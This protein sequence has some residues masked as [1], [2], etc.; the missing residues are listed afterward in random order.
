MNKEAV[1]EQEEKNINSN[2]SVI[3][4]LGKG[5]LCTVLYTF[6]MFQKRNVANVGYQDLYNGRE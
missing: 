3:T 2:V 4:K 1:Q 6:M 5:M